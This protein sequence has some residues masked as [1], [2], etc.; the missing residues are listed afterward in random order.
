MAFPKKI[1]TSL[2]ALQRDA[3]EWLNFY[4]QERV[5]SGRYCYGKTPLQTFLDS[6]HL[7]QEK[8]LGLLAQPPRMAAVA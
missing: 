5:H 4:N 2:E 8:Q 7:A 6:R 1:Y 3:D